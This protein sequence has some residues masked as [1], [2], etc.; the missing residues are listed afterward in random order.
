[1][2]TEQKVQY[3]TYLDVQV[4]EN[5]LMLIRATGYSENELPGVPKLMPFYNEDKDSAPEILELDFIN[6]QVGDSKKEKVT[7]DINIVID[8]SK[9]PKNIKGVKVVANNNADIVLL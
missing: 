2:R 5:Q 9:L 6:Q 3:L 4:F 1:M 7:F 8:R